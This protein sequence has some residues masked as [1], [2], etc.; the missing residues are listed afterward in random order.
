VCRFQDDFRRHVGV[1]GFLPSCRAQA[2]SIAGFQTG[3]SEHRI[4]S[5]QVVSSASTELQKFGRD[6]HT[7]RVQSGV[8][9]ARVA[10][11]VSV[12]A[13]HR[14]G[15]AGLQ[16]PAKYVFSGHRNGCPRKLEPVLKKGWVD[17]DFNI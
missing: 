16:S 17:Y 15:A 6:F 11:S 7:H 9:G 4:G 8:V 13:G 10:A 5:A 12:K 2:P 3:E 1:K 14:I